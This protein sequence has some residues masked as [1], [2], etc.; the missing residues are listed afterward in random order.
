MRYYVYRFNF[1]SSKI[2]NLPFEM[3][4]ACFLAAKSYVPSLF[5]E[6]IPRSRPIAKSRSDLLPSSFSVISYHGCPVE[7]GPNHST[8]LF[9]MM[10]G[11]EIKVLIYG[12]QW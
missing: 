10:I 3:N 9:Q 1:N 2:L 11:G 6:Q 5:R 12:G 4:G 8:L 7:E